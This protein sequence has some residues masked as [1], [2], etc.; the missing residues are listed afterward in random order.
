VEPFLELSII[1]V[2]KIMSHSIV[3]IKPDVNIEETAR[4]KAKKRIKKLPIV[5]NVLLVDIIF[6][7]DLIRADL[8]LA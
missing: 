1:K 3:K 6:S 4:L 5:E 7:M 2:K 8:K